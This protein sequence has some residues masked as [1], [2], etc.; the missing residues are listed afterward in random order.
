MILILFIQNPTSEFRLKFEN[1]KYSRHY[2]IHDSKISNNDP[3][4]L[5]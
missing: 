5:F 1:L 4:N 2:C 3:K